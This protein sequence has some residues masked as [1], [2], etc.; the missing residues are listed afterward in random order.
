MEG[1]P[2]RETKKGGADRFTLS[3][4]HPTESTAIIKIST[5]FLI[6]G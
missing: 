5:A 3:D 1:D 2:N 4:M 6:V